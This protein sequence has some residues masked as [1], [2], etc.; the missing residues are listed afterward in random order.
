[1]IEHDH[2]LDPVNVK[3]FDPA[4]MQPASAECGEC[5]RKLIWSATEPFPFVAPGTRTHGWW[6]LVQPGDPEWTHPDVK[7]MTDP[8][9][10]RALTRA[11]EIELGS[12]DV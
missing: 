3:P 4:D 5:G 2:E 8:K 9:A 1:M 6:K 12:T 7:G 11:A 10:I